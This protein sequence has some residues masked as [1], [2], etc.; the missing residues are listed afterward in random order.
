MMTITYRWER[1]ASTNYNYIQADVI[2]KIDFSVSTVFQTL[3]TVLQFIR[4][5]KNKVRMQQNTRV[6][7]S[8]LA[9]ITDK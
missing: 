6:Y 2:G 3:R 5:F 4:K 9:E 7:I 8:W 1:K